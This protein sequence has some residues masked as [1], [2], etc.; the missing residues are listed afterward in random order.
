MVKNNSEKK[1]LQV[2]S[3]LEQELHSLRN[4]IKKLPAYVYWKNKEGVY[5]GCND[6]VL[7]LAGTPDL[8]GKTDSQLPWKE[9]AQNISN[10]DNTVITT[11][12]PIVIEE[13]MIGANSKPVW[14]MT[15][16]IPLTDEQENT[17]GVLGVSIDITERKILEIELEK[18][19]KKLE[20]ANE[21]KNE[22]LKNM[23]QEVIGQSS[24]LKTAEEYAM[25]VRHHLES[26]IACMPGNVFWT[27]KNSVYM[28]CNDNVI[29]TFGLE[30]RAD[31]IGMTYE[32]M[33]KIAGW[34]EGQGDSFKRDDQEVMRTGEPK[35]NIEEPPI[36]DINGN[37]HHF[38]T[39]RVPLYD[40]H[41]Q[42]TGI[43]GISIDISERKKLEQELIIAKAAEEANFIKSLFIEN[44]S[45]DFKTPLNGIFGAMQV[46]LLTPDLPEDVR[47]MIDVQEKSVNRLKKMIDSILDFN[48]I[49]GGHVEIQHEELNLLEIIENIVHNLSYTVK[50]KNVDII[51]HYPP[52]VPKHLLSDSSSVTRILLNFISNAV[53]FTEKGYVAI[54]VSLLSNENEKAI[55][56]IQIEDTGLG[57]PKDKLGQIFERFHRLEFS[58]KGTAGHGIGLA[59]VKELISKLNGNVQVQSE[60]NKGSIFTVSLPF[61]LLDK[62][63]GISESQK[64]YQDIRILV[65]NDKKTATDIVLDQFNKETINNVNSSQLI[66]ELLRCAHTDAYQILIIDDEIEAIDPLELLKKIK[67]LPEIS[68]LMPILSTRPRDKEWFDQAR[69]TGYFDFIIKPLLPSELEIKIS[70]AWHKWQARGSV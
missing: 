19:K 26:I 63:L 15:H 29:K 33:T 30:S 37:V 50:E 39:N 49:Y 18:T 8:I 6:L 64:Q 32:K 57:I 35:I 69:M 41:Q 4:I 53:K 11:N 52:N 62:N 25:A 48:R 31:F 27:D 42:I 22:F 51:I 10:D 3:T 36:T 58:N 44:M 14:M 9:Q 17:I 66:S 43:V 59:V 47:K 68:N 38:L 13:N 28:G 24:S 70:D 46:L 65:V 7:E 54:S 34:T 12:K 5:L 40:E 23:S 45:H 2:A 21:T 60:L 20:I 55:V 61:D 56:Q 1:H 67:D 16:K